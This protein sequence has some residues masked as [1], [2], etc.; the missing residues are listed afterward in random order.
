MTDTK[1]S[2][3][4]LAAENRELDT[5]IEQGIQF[6][7]PK[8]SLLRFW[9]KPERTF[10]INQP[11]LGTLDWLSKEYIQMN[12][13]ETV[14]SQDPMGESRKLARYAPICARIVAI[15]VL[16]SYWKIK[17]FTPLLASYFL[18]RVNPKTLWKFTSLILELSN[19]G[20]FINSIRFLSTNRTT[21]PIRIEEKPKDP[22]NP[23]VPEA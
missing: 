16:N 14:L 5:L 22:K 11:Y 23:A 21:D 19:M 8:R 1:S 17:L 9:G 4:P 18:W 13:N 15:S 2:F 10:T 20:D 7:T 12:L 6:G 3:D